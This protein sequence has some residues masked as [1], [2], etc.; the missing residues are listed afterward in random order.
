MEN[1]SSPKD[2][3][4]LAAEVSTLIGNGKTDEAKLLL[5][6]VVTSSLKDA[7]GPTLL[8][9][10]RAYLAAEN[11]DLAEY[12]ELLKVTA[13][14]MKNIS[15]AESAMQDADRLDTVRKNLEA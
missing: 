6:Q 15:E 1:S 14:S 10:T 3:K 13:D 9:A 2:P 5:Q 8:D 12:E 7:Q 4:D 11:E